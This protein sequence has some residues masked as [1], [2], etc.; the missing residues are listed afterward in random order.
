MCAPVRNDSKIDT[1]KRPLSIRIEGV[2]IRG[3]TSNSASPHK[4][5]LTASSNAFRC[6]GRKPSFSTALFK[7]ATP[8]GI[9]A[10]FPTALHQPAALWR[11]R[12]RLLH[13]FT[14]LYIPFRCAYKY[15]S[16]T[17]SLPY[18]QGQSRFQPM[19][20]S[21]RSKSSIYRKFL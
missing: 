13:P 4:D 10:G 19:W 14:V 1:E 6:L 11:E 8:G 18:R 17:I 2:K 12:E 20:Q 7:K 3:T 21:E 5:T 15:R 16:A 9:S